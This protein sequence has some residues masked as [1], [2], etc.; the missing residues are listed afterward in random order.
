M[1]TD[2]KSFDQQTNSLNQFLTE[3]HV[4]QS[5][6]FVFGYWGLKG[7]V[8][9]DRFHMTSHPPYWC[10]KTITRR[11]FWCSNLVCGS[12]NFFWYKNFLLW[13]EIC[14]AVDHVSENAFLV[15][16]QIW[17]IQ[18]FLEPSEHNSKQSHPIWQKENPDGRK[19]RIELTTLRVLVRLL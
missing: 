12:W 11:P 13:R 6:D 7:Y 1:I 8:P 4:D 18:P 10:P 9:I 17:W 5:G 15:A 3:I 14:K 19:V 2:G 16:A